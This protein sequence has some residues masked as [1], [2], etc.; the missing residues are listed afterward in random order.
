MMS[1]LKNTI[2]SKKALI[3]FVS[4]VLIASIVLVYI[5]SIDTPTNTNTTYT[6]SGEFSIIKQVLETNQIEIEYSSLQYAMSEGRPIPDINVDFIQ[7]D[8]FTDFVSL[9]N[10]YQSNLVY[11]DYPTIINIDGANYYTRLMEGSTLTE[12]PDIDSLQ[13]NIWFWT[14]SNGLNQQTLTCYTND[15]ILIETPTS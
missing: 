2:T 12:L 3:V 8:K 6:I 10:E 9:A 5:M 1:E 4:I 15:L 7:V 14:I 11:T 13:Y